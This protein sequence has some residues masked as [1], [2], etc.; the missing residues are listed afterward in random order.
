MKIL[1]IVPMEFFLQK[2]LILFHYTF[3]GQFK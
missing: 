3:V 1:Q 2:N